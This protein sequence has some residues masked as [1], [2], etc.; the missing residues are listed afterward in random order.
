MGQDSSVPQGTTWRAACDRCDGSDGRLSDMP[1]VIIRSLFRHGSRASTVK[2]E[3]PPAPGC[4]PFPRGLGPC[5]V[6]ATHLRCG[7]I[8]YVEGLDAVGG[9]VAFFTRELFR[10]SRSLGAL[11]ARIDSM[12]AWS[13]LSSGCEA[14]TARVAPA[15]TL[16][17]PRATRRS[18]G[19]PDGEEV[20][21]LWVYPAQIDWAKLLSA[22]PDAIDLADPDVSLFTVG[23]YVYFR[24]GRQRRRQSTGGEA[25]ARMHSR[26]GAIGGGVMPAEVQIISA[27]VVAFDPRGSLQF[28]APRRLEKAA[29]ERLQRLGRFQPV[30]V[31]KWAAQGAKYVCW[32]RPGELLPDPEGR[33]HCLTS[34][35]GLAFLFRDIKEQDADGKD[36]YFEVAAVP[37]FLSEPIPGLPCASSLPFS[38]CAAPAGHREKQRCRLFQLAGRGQWPLVLHL[39][40]EYPRCAR[41]CGE[42]GETLLHHCARHRLRDRSVL[43]SLR[44]GAAPYDAK[45][46]EGKTAEEL[47]D[48]AF[49]SLCREIWGLAPDLFEDAERWF[50]FWDRNA[51]SK[52]EPVELADA[53]AA[54]FRLSDVGRRWVL[55]YANVRHRSGITRSRFLG[56]HGLLHELQFSSVFLEMR[57][58][59]QTPPLFGSGL[60]P[61]ADEEH[62]RLAF[63]E[64]RF[65]RLRAQYGWLPGARAPNFAFRLQMPSPFPGAGLDAK[66][67]MTNARQMLSFSLAQTASSP[68]RLW[69]RGFRVS[70]AGQEGLDD[71]GLTKAWGQ[72]LAYALWGNHDY[73][74]SSGGSWCFFK[75]DTTETLDL[76][77]Q[78]IQ[79]VDLYRWT[80]H[81][82]AYLIYQHCLVDCSLCPWTFRALQRFAHSRRYF[83]AACSTGLPEWPESC[84]GEDNM[85]E[86]LATFDPGLAS[87]LWR[88]LHEMTDDELRWLDFTCAGEDLVPGGSDLT[89]S[90]AN[91]SRYVR[92][93]CARH[94][95]AR[96]RQGLQAFVEGFLEVL[97]PELIADAFEG[98]LHRMLLG[99]DTLTDNELNEL[100][101]LVVPAG[102]VPQK[103][104]DA[105]QVREAAR[106]FFQAARAGSGAF[107]SRLLEFW[108]GSSRIPLTGVQAIQPR[109]KLQV[110]VQPDGRGVKRIGSW[111]QHRLPEGHTCGNELWLPLQDSYEQ[112][113]ERLRLAV[114][115]FE[116]GFALR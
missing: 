10:R 14:V 4:L 91:K 74:E 43:E 116:S 84:E 54:A 6:C 22:A 5:G 102:L 57:K 80:G 13:R 82:L 30:T 53:L 19:I 46:A 110:M 52:L 32:V 65:A 81:F 100:E 55:S 23:G 85:L 101:R 111:P 83:A 7:D 50:E 78:P 35:G 26:G 105:P 17:L 106:W 87:G 109:P 95:V 2:G 20:R 51:N 71:G 44:D 103:L 97:P 1:R 79:A 104:R 90:S 86:D 76:D 36:R 16:A 15:H 40:A 108:T 69:L 27:N 59:G 38:I 21:F 112:T 3:V 68:A 39:L 18:A 115:N 72:E 29:C 66:A 98:S 47:G 33:P 107:R 31:Q 56:P 96:C 67:R 75:P 113:V 41:E 70:F 89:V 48:R 63:L 9:G 45:N 42:K 11:A 99:A 77:G 34:F 62:V 94:L 88:V 93:T 61:L 37:H 73:F 28:S 64:E 24:S 114:E 58:N 8:L 49:R 12:R 60:P 92:L 25:A